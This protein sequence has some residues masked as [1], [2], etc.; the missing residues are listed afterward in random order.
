MRDHQ[1]FV[2]RSLWLYSAI[3]LLYPRRFRR[4][5]GQQMIVVFERLLENEPFGPWRC[6][7]IELVPT[8]VR[9]HVD[10]ALE[11]L[12]RGF[13]SS[14][15]RVA[16]RVTMAALLPVGSYVVLLGWTVSRADVI[17]LTTCFALM[18]AGIVWARGRGWACSGGAMIGA[19]AA[20]GLIV[21][22]TGFT[23][24]TNPNIILVAPLLAAAAAT[25]ALILATYVRLMIEGV[26]WS[27]HAAA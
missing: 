17:A 18:V 5:F 4:Q 16:L 12:R 26:S 13:R 7:L 9:E 24:N 25:V 3:L 10:A 22:V 21:A 19:I 15:L 2:R 27:R 1:Q 8:L 6:V 20:V 14:R 23:E 11:S